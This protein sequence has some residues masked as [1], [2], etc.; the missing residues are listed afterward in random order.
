M[1]NI[2]FT[3]IIVAGITILGK[4]Q[5]TIIEHDGFSASPQLLLSEYDDANGGTRLSFANTTT[6]D[7]FQ[8]SA[9]VGSAHTTKR[10]N[11]S[12]NDISTWV[13]DGTNRRFGIGTISPTD[14]LHVKVSGSNDGIRI[15]G[16]NT[17]DSRLFISNGEGNHFLFDDQ[18]DSNTF[19]ISSA[20]EFKINTNGGQK[21]R[22][23]ESG[24]V[25]IGNIISQAVQMNGTEL[26][27]LSD[28]A[29]GLDVLNN[30]T[31]A[32][33]GIRA[34]ISSAGSGSTSGVSGQVTGIMGTGDQYGVI[35]SATPRGMGE[36]ASYAV[37]ANGD[38]A[39]AGALV[40]TSDRKLKKNIK[41][42]DSVIDKVMNLRVTE[43]EYKQGEFPGLNLALGPQIGFIAQEVQKVFP[44]L[45]KNNQYSFSNEKSQEFEMYT[46][47]SMAIIPILTKA[48][49]EQQAIIN[50]QQDLLSQYQAQLSSIIERVSRI[51]G[52]NNLTTDDTTIS[53]EQ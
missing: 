31:D 6:T 2:L 32:T 15:E 27:V 17:G 47:N 3:L 44:D 33:I 4:G 18:D 45:V 42:V 25:G 13:F 19:S 40:H 7:E 49:Q 35:G 24:G 36:P 34:T 28:L 46:L 11:L 43:Y 30:H 48:I 50:Q 29:V 39:Y 5:H 52:S 41:S 8:F 51:E 14:K 37:Y 21:M 53:E 10:L 20:N 12:Y 9:S 16:D 23:S 38:L 1:K 22:I 26:Y